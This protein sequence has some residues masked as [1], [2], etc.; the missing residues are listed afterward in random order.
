M[1]YIYLEQLKKVV[2]LETVDADCPADS[3]NYIYLK[4]VDKEYQQAFVFRKTL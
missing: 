2:N 1:K 4:L 3:F